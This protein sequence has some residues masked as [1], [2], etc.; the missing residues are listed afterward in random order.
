M[1]PDRQYRLWVGMIT[2]ADDD[3]RLVADPVWLRV[4]VFGYQPKTTA[5]HVAEAMDALAGVGLI[6][7]YRC[8]GVLY[9]QFPSWSDH[10]KVQHP[11]S[12]ALP[13]P[14]SETCSAIGYL[15]AK[16]ESS[17][18]LMSNTVGSDRIGSEGSEGREPSSGA[19]EAPVALPA[20]G[21]D[22]GQPP[23]NDPAPKDVT[24]HTPAS[25]VKALG[26]APIL[27]QVQRLRDPSWWQAELRANPS[28][29]LAVQVLRAE[30]WIKSNPQR[31]PKK[32]Y[33]G[34][35]HNWFARET[36]GR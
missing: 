35:M 15:Q 14:S 6:R 16:Q 31:S 27:G 25:V 13:P 22:N 7:V 33:A 11:T 29:D 10:Q 4:I 17:G 19:H 5:R 23:E 3:G 24:F 32:D 20:L 21:T 36:R 12:S 26:R 9:A 8:A 30:A 28:V 1:L 18:T 34:F 2:E